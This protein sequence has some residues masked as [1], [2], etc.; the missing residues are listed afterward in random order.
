[1]SKSTQQKKDTGFRAGTPILGLILAITLAVVAFGISVPLVSFLGDQFPDIGNQFDEFRANYKD[2]EMV[3]DY[4]VEVIMAALL[5]FVLLGAAM[6]IS[7]IALGT[8]PEKEIWKEMPPSPADKKA[9]IKLM[10]KDLR[11]AKKGARA[12]KRQQKKG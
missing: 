7:S 2:N 10:K 1:M 4:I 8:N 11:E 3:H 9:M 5:W 12:Q 6:M